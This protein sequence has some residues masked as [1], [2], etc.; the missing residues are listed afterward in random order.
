M[1]F[2]FFLFIDV[3]VGAVVTVDQPGAFYRRLIQTVCGN[4]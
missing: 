2:V 4:H 1:R 3:A